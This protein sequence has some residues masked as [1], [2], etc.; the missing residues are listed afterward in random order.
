MWEERRSCKSQREK[1]S[2]G[3]EEQVKYGKE[4]K[5]MKAGA[6]MGSLE[7]REERMSHRK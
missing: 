2:R 4:Q 5:R 3:S 6:G 1:G 7:Q